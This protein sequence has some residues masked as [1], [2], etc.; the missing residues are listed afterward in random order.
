[1]HRGGITPGYNMSGVYIGELVDDYRWMIAIRGKAVE[2][3][4]DADNC[5]SIFRSAL[6]GLAPHG[7]QSCRSHACNGDYD[8]SASIPLR[9]LAHRHGTPKS[10]N[11]RPVSVTLLRIVQHA[12]PKPKLRSLLKYLVFWI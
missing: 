5:R 2:C 4:G 1:M 6:P 9:M 7:R 8:P 10:R 12:V 3:H 11:S